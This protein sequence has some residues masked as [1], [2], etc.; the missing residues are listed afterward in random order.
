M[1]TSS[2]F[3]QDLQHDLSWCAFEN[4]SSGKQAAC[5]AACCAFS[6]STLEIA[7]HF[8]TPTFALT[9]RKQPEVWRWAVISS[10]GLILEEGC[11]PSQDEAKRTAAEALILA[12]LESA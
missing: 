12:R 11:E 5:A 1:T 3:R 4:L 2:P 9:E 6:L 8:N 7:A 10:G